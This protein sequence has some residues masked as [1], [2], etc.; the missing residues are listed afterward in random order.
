M[1]ESFVFHGNWL[2][3]YNNIPDPELKRQ[4][5]EAI[6]N[7]G[8][9][10]ELPDKESCNPL[11]LALLSPIIINMDTQKKNYGFKTHGRRPTVIGSIDDEVLD[12]YFSAG[13]TQVEIAKLLG[14]SQS[15]VSRRYRRWRAE[16]DKK[17]GKITDAT[18]EIF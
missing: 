11:L 4:F 18:E 2:E 7:Y 9:L 3:M 1:F 5:I 8:V 16:Q 13:K 15:T 6:M 10:S 12:E 17:E 14:I